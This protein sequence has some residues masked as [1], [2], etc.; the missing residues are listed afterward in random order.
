MGLR[1]EFSVQANRAAPGSS[2]PL[3]PR[4]PSTLQMQNAKQRE[5]PPRGIEIDVD[6]AFE[7]RSEQRRAFVVKTTPAHIERFDLGGA[8]HCGSP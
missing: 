5:Q 1:T 8:A 4:I 3:G 7:A 2:S 6:F